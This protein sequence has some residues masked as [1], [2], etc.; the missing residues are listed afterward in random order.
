[1]SRA[2]DIGNKGE[3][4][5]IDYLVSKGYIILERNWKFSRAEIDIIARL[6]DIIVFVEVK[7]RSSDHFGRP[8]EF[9]DDRKRELCI[10]AAFAYMQEKKWDWELRFD[11]IG[12][13]FQS[14]RSYK[15]RH[16][17]DAFF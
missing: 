5:A 7:T 15:I 17:E 1:M 16:F 13:D 6:G 11:I 3:Q 2:H 10:D 8:E 9:V 4:L 14:E 12:I